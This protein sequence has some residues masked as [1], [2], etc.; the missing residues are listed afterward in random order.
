MAPAKLATILV[1]TIVACTF[2][3]A[4]AAPITAAQSCAEQIR[5]FTNCLARDEIRQQ[6]C[7][8][9]E[10]TSCLCQL[11]RAVAVPCIPH[12]RHGHRCPVSAVPP[13]VQMAELQRLP[14]FKGLKCLRAY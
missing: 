5:Y 14:C 8:V 1:V 12:R 11:K 2:A 4:S 6:C 3:S 10:N 9:V 7:V 13:A